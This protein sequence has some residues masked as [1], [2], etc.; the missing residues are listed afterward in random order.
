LS[1]HF[2]TAA[3]R[4]IVLQNALLAWQRSPH[5]KIGFKFLHVPHAIGEVFIELAAWDDQR[6]SSD[7]TFQQEQRHLIQGPMT[8]GDIP[9]FPFDDNRAISRLQNRV[10]TPKGT[11]LRQNGAR[12]EAVSLLL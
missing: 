1:G 9:S 6:A 3:D 7:P 12:F 4:G 11:I 8:G 2:V 10:E 5:F